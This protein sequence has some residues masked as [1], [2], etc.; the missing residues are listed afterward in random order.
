MTDSEVIK[1]LECCKENSD[2][3]NCRGCTGYVSYGSRCLEN[4]IQD[5][6]ELINRL[7]TSLEKSE[8]VEDTSA[9][10]IKTQERDIERYKGVIKLL[11]ADV[12]N[13]KVE[14]YKELAEKLK[15][16]FPESDR[17]NNS[18]AIYYDFYC[19]LIDQTTDEL[20]GA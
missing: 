6:L 14:A 18:P 19:E 7:K 16:A 11:E 3:E 9:A 15:E 12:K 1:A 5:A 10:L 20:V 13:A 17:N 8:R 2:C 4:I